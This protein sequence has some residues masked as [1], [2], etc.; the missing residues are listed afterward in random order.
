MDIGPNPCY[1]RLSGGLI[2]VTEIRPDCNE[3]SG[4]NGEM[5]FDA[6]RAV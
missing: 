1:H 2:T 4:E 3:D 5:T 6:N